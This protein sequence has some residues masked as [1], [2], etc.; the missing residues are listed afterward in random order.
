MFP[1]RTRGPGA[2]GKVF[3]LRLVPA[4]GVA[5]PDCRV[6]VNR[7]EWDDCQRCPDFEPCYRL[8]LATWTL[9]AAVGTA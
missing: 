1:E 9:R 5:G 2:S 8:G 6:E 7:Q 4:A 3:S